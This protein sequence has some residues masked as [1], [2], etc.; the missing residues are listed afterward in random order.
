MAFFAVFSLP[1]PKNSSIAPFLQETDSLQI[2]FDIIELTEILQGKQTQVVLDTRC[3]QLFFSSISFFTVLSH[4]SLILSLCPLLSLPLSSL[5]SL[6]LSSL[7]FALLSLPLSYLL[8]PLRH[9]GEQSLL[10]PSLAKFQGPALCIYIDAQM[11]PEE[12]A[13]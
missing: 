8:S 2:F 6:T 4:L 1:C 5:L 9:Y 10:L 7:S 3:A 13:R 12:M 11:T